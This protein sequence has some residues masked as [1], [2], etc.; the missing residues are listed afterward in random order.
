GDD[1]CRWARVVILA[2]RDEASPGEMVAFPR[3]FSPE[4]LNFMTWFRQELAR[5]RLATELDQNYFH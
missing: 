1:Y 3:H 4:T 2:R 5:R